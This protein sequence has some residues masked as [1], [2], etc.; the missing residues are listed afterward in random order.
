MSTFQRHAAHHF[1]RSEAVE[2][3]S[4]RTQL[5]LGSGHQQIS[6]S[7]AAWQSERGL[8]FAEQDLQVRQQKPAMALMQIWSENARNGSSYWTNEAND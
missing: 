7:L 5:V 3:I 8:A 4:P 1:T 2:G 6:G